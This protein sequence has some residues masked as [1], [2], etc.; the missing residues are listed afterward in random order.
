MDERLWGHRFS[1]ICCEERAGVKP[2]TML[3]SILAY[4]DGEIFRAGRCHRF[5]C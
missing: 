4:R 1:C 3:M 5:L 2:L